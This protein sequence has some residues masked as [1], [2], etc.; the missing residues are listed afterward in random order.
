[1]N[2]KPR[3]KVTLEVEFNSFNELQFILNKVLG[4]ASQHQK[5]ERQSI[6]GSLYEYTFEIIPDE[7]DFREEIIN[8]KR[9]LI[10]K[11]KIN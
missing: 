7:A 3:K 5:H 1:M 10:I 9:C 8:G 4:M 2:Q 11:S 6:A